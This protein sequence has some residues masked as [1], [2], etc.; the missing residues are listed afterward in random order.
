MLTLPY[1]VP[2]SVAN[3]VKAFHN[4]AGYADGN[5]I[6]ESWTFTILGLRGEP[7]YVSP[8]MGAEPLIDFVAQF[9]IPLNFPTKFRYRICCLLA[10]RRGGTI[11][12]C[13]V[14]HVRTGEPS[15][16]TQK[17]HQRVTDAKANTTSAVKKIRTGFSRATKSAGAGDTGGFSPSRPIRPNESYTK[18]YTKI[19]WNR[20][21]STGEETVTTAK[22]ARFHRS[23]VWTGVRTPGFGK[24]K[25]SRL[26]VNPHTVQMRTTEV[27]ELMAANQS[28]TKLSSDKT[29]SRAGE[30]TTYSTYYPGATLPA[31]TGKAD[32]IAVKRLQGAIGSGVQQNLAESL[33]TLGQTLDMLQGNLQKITGSLT[34]LRGGNIPKAVKILFGNANPRYRQRGGPKVGMDLAKNW[35]ELQYGWKPLINDVHWVMQKLAKDDLSNHRVGRTTTS[36]SEW[37][38]S[39][40][41]LNHVNYPTVK[42]GSKVVTSH[43]TVKYKISWSVSSQLKLLLSQAGFTNPVALTWE[44]L[45]FSFVVDW[46]LPIGP[47][48]EQISAWDGLSFHS[49]CRVAFTRQRTVS[50]LTWAQDNPGNPLNSFT[51]GRGNYYDEWIL[52]TRS[53]LT[54][55]PGSTLPSFKS[56]LSVDHGLNA[57][58]LLRALTK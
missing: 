29:T 50:V 39:T 6:A 18:P 26:P 13:Q 35:L 12:L 43:T 2:T 8:S 32:T 37:S 42:V 24:L 31:G 21:A 27:D 10:L 22:L 48:L 5:P 15:S 38:Q 53:K 17:P 58:A 52:Y 23:R 54:S 9:D 7:L 51:F 33:A 45:P 25:G 46:F 28:K 47:Y 1:P 4:V 30:L 36:G 16:N 14:Y 55:F 57:I 44:L 20:S 3:A 19:V 49:G 11:K 40:T 34:A 56:P 41:Q